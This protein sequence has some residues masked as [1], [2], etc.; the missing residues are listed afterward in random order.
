MELQVREN[1]QLQ[2]VIFRQIADQWWLSKYAVLIRNLTG[3]IDDF[4]QGPSITNMLGEC[5]IISNLLGFWEI[6]KILIN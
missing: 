4:R 2:G 5:Q 1:G 6:Y 3:K